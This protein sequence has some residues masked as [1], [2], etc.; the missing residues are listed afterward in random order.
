MH[1][2]PHPCFVYVNYHKGH[3]KFL[4]LPDNDPF[5]QSRHISKIFVDE[6]FNHRSL[7]SDIAI[8]ALEAPAVLSYFVRPVCYPQNTNS[9]LEEYQ[10][11]QG[12]LGTVLGWGA[13]E[14]ETLAQDLRMT[15]LP[16]I[17]HQDCVNAY[18]D[19][20]ASMTRSTNYCAGYRNGTSLCNGMSSQYF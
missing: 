11:A 5:V 8:M 10:L 17:S 1:V 4:A 19:F 14:N 7:D 12:N 18:R 16:V 6:A 15:E 3:F 2:S 9:F 20:F 13:T